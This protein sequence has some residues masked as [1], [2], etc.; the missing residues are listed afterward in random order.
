MINKIRYFQV[1]IFF[2]NTF[3]NKKHFVR[4]AFCFGTMCS[5][6][7]ERDAHFVHDVCFAS[8][9]R[10]AREDAVAFR[11]GEKHFYFWC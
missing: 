6:P 11:G 9:V 7:A 10:F 8:D 5:A 1:G 2:V 3:Q 4:S